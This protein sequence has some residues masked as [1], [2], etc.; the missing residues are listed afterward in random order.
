MAEK[1]N[2]DLMIVDSV[3][4]SHSVVEVLADS[5]SNPDAFYFGKGYIA[6]NGKK[7]IGSGSG[8]TAG[9]NADNFFA[10]PLIKRIREATYLGDRLMIFHP[11]FETDPNVEVVLMAL[12]R[13]G[14]RSYDL[15]NEELLKRHKRRQWGE[16][17]Q[18]LNPYEHSLVAEPIHISRNIS[19]INFSDIILRVSARIPKGYPNEGMTYKSIFGDDRSAMV[20]FHYNNGAVFAEGKNQLH[21]GIALRK[22]NPNFV[23]VPNNKMWIEADGVLQYKWLYSDVAELIVKSTDNIDLHAHFLGLEIK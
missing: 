6:H 16:L 7:I 3:D 19:F 1:T 10:K 17:K 23:D 5:A 9:N 2:K 18:S 4:T 21:L 22:P 14:G 20:N 11:Y 12:K 13:R 15:N 8:N